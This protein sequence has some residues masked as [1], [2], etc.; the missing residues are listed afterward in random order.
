MSNATKIQ[1]GMQRQLQQWRATLAAGDKRLGWK[2]GF[3]RVVDQQKFE[4]PSAMVGYLARQQQISSGQ[5]YTIPAGS[6]ILVEAEIALLIGADLPANATLT[7]ARNV[8]QGYAAALELVDTTRTASNDIEEILAGNLFHAAVVMGASTVTNPGHFSASLKING[9]EVRSLEADRLAADFGAIVQLVA[10]ILGQQG[11][12]L[13]A[14]DWIICGAIAAPIKVHGGDT[15]V[16]TLEPLGTITLT[17]SG[18]S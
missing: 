17:I 6:T 4:L 18:E 13:E 14:G 15:V 9:I 11:E 7:Q 3:N 8:I 16:L 1:Q 5:S 10:N 2:I 12:R